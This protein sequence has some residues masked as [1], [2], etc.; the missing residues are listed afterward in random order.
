M[1]NKFSSMTGLLWFY[2]G[3]KHQT[4]RKHRQEWTVVYA[5]EHVVQRMPISLYTN[6]FIAQ[7]IH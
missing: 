4:R 1:H 5:A 3:I 2:N 7:F 6:T